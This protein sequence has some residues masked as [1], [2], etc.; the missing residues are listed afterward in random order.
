VRQRRLA[1]A[2]PDSPASVAPDDVH[3][4]VGLAESD[5]RAVRRRDD[6]GLL[7]ARVG[8]PTEPCAV[9]GRR[10]DLPLAAPVAR[11]DDGARARRRFSRTSRRSI[12]WAARSDVAGREYEHGRCACSANDE[13]RTWLSM[14]RPTPPRQRSPIG[15]RR[16]FASMHFQSLCSRDHPSV[17]RHGRVLVEARSRESPGPCICIRLPDLQPAGQPDSKPVS[18]RAA[19]SPPPRR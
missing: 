3:A 1:P 16:S 9:R 13:A 14:H 10:V 4:R 11:E 15:H 12:G 8:E 18:P 7:A 19:G 6:V 17:E 5:R 2:E